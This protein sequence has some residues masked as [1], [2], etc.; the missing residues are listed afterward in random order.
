M[1]LARN[2]ATLE[3][4]DVEILAP[5]YINAYL[6]RSGRGLLAPQ[7]ATH[8]WLAPYAASSAPGLARR[9]ASMRRRI[10]QLVS[11]WRLR[12][13]E[14]DIFHETGF[15]TDP[16]PLSTARRVLTVYDMIDEL[17]LVADGRTSPVFI[18]A[19][20][21]AILRAD[22]V[23]CISEQTRIDLLT[24]LPIPEAKTTVV[25][26]GCRSSDE[27]PDHAAAAGPSCPFILFV[28]SRD[29]YKNFDGVLRA[30]SLSPRLRR[31]FALVAFGG[32]SFTAGERVLAA[33]LG[34]PEDRL[35][36]VGGDDST[37][38]ALYRRARVC[39]YPS[40][41]EGFG[42]IPLEAMTFGCPVVTTHRGS[43]KEV[44]AGAA[45]IVDPGEPESIAAGLATAAFDE[46]RRSQ[47][48]TA[49]LARA[50]S[51]T[52]QR[53]ATETRAAYQRLLA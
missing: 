14:P 10:N 41:Y 28:G 13:S 12:R 21:A 30:Y 9:E 22:H 36:Q 40:Q 34:I 20:H 11:R 17:L 23:I 1:E 6:R 18:Q 42:L 51:F 4:S 29:T 47:L 15:E 26:L 44:V 16:M 8:D 48:R 33:E 53:C 45:E 31:D 43:L 46:A 49:G 35:L 27:W 52:W 7:G 25:Y 37:L 3:S 24:L 2:L 19:K 32:G 5:V 38:V 50:S 39:V